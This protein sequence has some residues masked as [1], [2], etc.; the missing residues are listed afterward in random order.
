[1][2]SLSSLA[3]VT[4]RGGPVTPTNVDIQ[5]NDVQDSIETRSWLIYTAMLEAAN[6][7]GGAIVD[8]DRITYV[9]SLKRHARD[10]YP[11]VE[12]EDVIKTAA[13]MKPVY[14]YLRTTGNATI[15]QRNWQGDTSKN[16]WSIALTWQIGNTA[17][18]VIRSAPNKTKVTAAEAGE[19]R[20]AAPV[21]ITYKEVTVTARKQVGAFFTHDDAGFHCPKCPDIFKTEASVRGHYGARHFTRKG[22]L[23]QTD[24]ANVDGR[25][26]GASSTVR[27][28]VVQNRAR[29]THQ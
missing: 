3:R 6:R 27:S 20:A 16:L 10:L 5:R 19:D 9:D 21:T 24:P 4:R 15:L 23:R 1:M 22:L 28:A 29:T 12:W 25:S 26:P 14:S 13:F 8:G 17:T 2:P 7:N 11:T 18:R